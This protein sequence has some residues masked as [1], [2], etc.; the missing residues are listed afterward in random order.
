MPKNSCGIC[1]FFRRTVAQDNPTFTSSIK[2]GNCVR[3]P[4]IV[5]VTPVADGKIQFSNDIPWVLEDFEC[6]EFK[7]I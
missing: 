1:K 7:E 6:G 3:Y 4:P 5:H 2:G